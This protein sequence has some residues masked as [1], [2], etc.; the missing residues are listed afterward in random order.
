VTAHVFATRLAT[1]RPLLCDGAMGTELFAR[2]LVAG[3]CPERWNLE[4]GETVAEVSRAY[5]A[6]GAEMVET[7]TFG[8]SPL[9]LAAYGLAGRAAEINRRGAEL[10]RLGAG[11]A[12]IAG[13]CGPCGDLLEPHGGAARDAVARSFETQLGALAEGGVDAFCVETMTDLDE[14]VL[15]VRAARRVAPGVPVLAS[16][17]FDA[18]PRGFFTLMGNALADCVR[19]LVDEGADVVG[20]NCGSG[21]AVMVEVG[22]AL[23]AATRAPLVVQANAGLPEQRDGRLVYT[24]GPELFAERA[25]ELVEVGVAVIGGCCGTTPD[26]IA[27]L[28]AMID[29]VPGHAT[30][31]AP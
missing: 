8:G 1:G 7:N 19:R 22:R 26:H 20:A 30:R 24:E 10:A 13:S 28:R 11:R 29:G 31:P 21:I 25:R 23:R 16:M 3:E 27:A 14:A 9:K 18:T 12:L 5:A 2:G 4:R 17:T 6:A 15:A